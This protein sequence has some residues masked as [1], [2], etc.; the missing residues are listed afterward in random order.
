MTTQLNPV[1]Y[2]KAI[3]YQLANIVTPVP[4]YAAFNRNFAT[5]PK[6]ITWMLR[7]VHQPVYTGST[8]SI[9]GIDRPTFQISIFTQV[10]EDGFTI[11][12]QILQSLH[13]YSGLFGGA[14]NGFQISK[15]D[16]QWLY[17]SYDNEDK[18]AQIFLD[19]TI[20]IPA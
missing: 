18:L 13:G 17:N 3:Q 14:T 5:Q 2:G 8:Q 12:N 20:D 6:F 19:C 16:V 1:Q 10:I 7:N 15:A 4:V 11:S 9:K